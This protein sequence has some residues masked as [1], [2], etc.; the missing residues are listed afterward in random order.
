MRTLWAGALLWGLPL[1][2]GAVNFDQGAKGTNSAGFLE[3]AP[4]ARAAALGEAYAAVADE[5]SALYWNPAALTRIPKRSAAL[6][7]AEYVEDSYFDYAAIAANL[8][9]WGVIGSGMQF[10]SAGKLAHTDD[11]GG[12]LGTLYP[13][14]LAVSLGYAYKL[15]GFEIMEDFNGVSVGFS[16]KLVRAEIAETDT[17]GAF[18]IGLL[19]PEYFE[20]LRCA[21]TV[22]NL[23]RGLQFEDEF[24]PL[25]TAFRLGSVVKLRPGWIASADIVFPRNNRVYPTV[26]TE[27]LWPAGKDM[28][29]AA[30][31]GFNANTVGD[32]QGFSGASFGAGV[33]YMGMSVDYGFLPLGGLGQAHRVSLSF[34]F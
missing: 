20:R 8:G 18:D 23:G 11:A 30:R 34:G 5:A 13:F 29:L 15:D 26:G 32:I 27:Y 1:S 21:F 16:A 33:T 24:A 19:T 9:K 17:T 31:A 2:A 12:A 7:H 10:F 28:T 25:P 3:L 6:M 14:G 22:A 4:G